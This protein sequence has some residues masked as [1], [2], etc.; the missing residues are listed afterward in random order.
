[1][2]NDDSKITYTIIALLVIILG[3]IAYYLR[4]NSV[5]Q[6]GKDKISIITE[7][8]TVDTSKFNTTTNTKVTAT[9]TNATTT[10]P[11]TENTTPIK[12]DN[13][14]L[15]TS[16]GDIE[17]AVTPTSAPNTVTN[18]LTLASAGF[19]NDIR[20]HRII[21]GFMIQA[22]DPLSKDPTMKTRWGTGGPGYSFKDELSGKETYPQ[23]TVA[24]ANSGPNTNGSQ[25]FIVTASPSAP[26]PPAYTVFGKVTKGLDVAL[27]IQETPRDAADRPIT[28]VV[29]KSVELK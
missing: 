12:A 25:F 9:T 26:L 4:S 7:T 1:M 21:N 17:F 23:G 22:G 29:I 3:G 11:M 28:D 14:V 19:Y 5:D 27:K 18:F 20:F 16:M 13:V 10:K 8:K 15:H 2:Y 24:M 6:V